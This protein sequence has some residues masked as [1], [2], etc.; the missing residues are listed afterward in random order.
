MLRNLTRRAFTTATTQSLLFAKVCTNGQGSM[1]KFREGQSAQSSLTY[2][3]TWNDFAYYRLYPG[4]ETTNT[5]DDLSKNVMM[6]EPDECEELN[7]ADEG[8]ATYTNKQ[9]DG[10]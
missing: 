5:P 9:E 4:A 6:Q 7:A 3:T 2:T 8:I 1:L 10:F